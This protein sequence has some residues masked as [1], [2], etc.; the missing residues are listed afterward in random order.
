MPTQSSLTESPAGC[1]S[2]AH[3]LEKISDMENGISIL[4]KIHKDVVLLDSIPAMVNATSNIPADASSP[5]P[6]TGFSQSSNPWFIL[7]AR[8]KMMACSTPRQSG[9]WITAC[10][11]KRRGRR[12]D[13]H[14]LSQTQHHGI[15]LKNRFSILKKH[16][17]GQLSASPTQRTLGG[18]LLC[19]SPPAH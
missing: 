17:E 10:G 4:R 7:G 15:A 6:N 1:R 19:S 13:W 11:G 18:S 5:E 14:P 16:E 3:L 2:C 9:V 12:S 8:P